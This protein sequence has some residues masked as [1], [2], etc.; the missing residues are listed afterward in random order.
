MKLYTIISIITLI[1]I[2]IVISYRFRRYIKKYYNRLNMLWR[3]NVILPMS[4]KKYLGNNNLVLSNNCYRGY[5]DN[6]YAIINS[7]VEFVELFNR[8]PITSRDQL[9]DI[10]SGIGL[11]CFAF[12]K[13][14][15][16]GKVIGVELNKRSYKCSLKNLQIMNMDNIEFVNKSI[17]DYN[18]PS[19]ITYI[20]IFNPF[21]HSLKLFEK[22]INKCSSHK[23]LTMIWMNI[24]VSKNMINILA[25]KCKSVQYG[26]K[27]YRY[28]IIKF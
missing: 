11:M 18:I 4:W 6:S 20:Y 25:N 5:R 27:Q 13:R 26:F 9:L 23:N 10:G 8:F 1:I 17:F 28:I 16:F 12:K 7:P 19:S 2:C 22:L 21:A 15:N 24:Y 3:K 14:Y